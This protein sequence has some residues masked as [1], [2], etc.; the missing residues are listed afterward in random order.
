MNI[1]L[2]VKFFFFFLL[3][4]TSGHE[5]YYSTLGLSSDASSTDVKKAFRQRSLEEHPDKNEG[6]STDAFL[7]IKAAYDVLGNPSKRARYDA[8][9]DPNALDSSVASEEKIVTTLKDC[10]AVIEEHSLE[11]FVLLH[12]F[13]EHKRVDADAPWAFP[14]LKKEG[15]FLVL[16]VPIFDAE[17]ELTEYFGI[18][19]FPVLVLV[20]SR[21]RSKPFE[22]AASDVASG[23]LGPTLREAALEL[24]MASGEY[25]EATHLNWL[26]TNPEVLDLDYPFGSGCQRVILLTHSSEPHFEFYMLA[27]SRKY[28]F[29]CFFHIVHSSGQAVVSEGRA[30]RSDSLFNLFNVDYQNS[31]AL[32]LYHPI[33]QSFWHV[34]EMEALEERLALLPQQDK[35]FLRDASLETLPIAGKSLVLIAPANFDSSKNQARYE[36]AKR[37]L[38]AAQRRMHPREIQRLQVEASTA[39]AL[40]GIGSDGSTVFEKFTEFCAE[41][42]SGGNAQVACLWMRPKGIEEKDKWPRFLDEQARK[43][44]RNTAFAYG[45]DE[46]TVNFPGLNPDCAT[47]ALFEGPSRFVAV[48]EDGMATDSSV[49]SCFDGSELSQAAAKDWWLKFRGT[50]RRDD[51]KAI[52][53]MPALPIADILSREVSMGVGDF[54]VSLYQSYFWFTEFLGSLTDL[55][56]NFDIL[57]DPG[58]NPEEALKVGLS[59][60]V[61]LVFALIG[62]ALHMINSLSETPSSPRIG[63][64]SGIEPYCSLDWESDETE[65]RIY[66][67]PLE[68]RDPGTL[69]FWSKISRPSLDVRWGLRVK[70]TNSG[71]VFISFVDPKGAASEAGSAPFRLQPGDEVVEVRK[72]LESDGASGMDSIQECMRRE[73]NLLV[74]VARRKT[75]WG[76]PRCKVGLPS[77]NQKMHK[78]LR[79]LAKE[80]QDLVVD[81]NKLYEM[82]V[83]LAVQEEFSSITLEPKFEANCNATRPT[84][85]TTPAHDLKLKAMIGF[86]S[87]P[88]IESASSPLRSGDRLISR[89]E[90]APGSLQVHVA[91]WR[92]LAKCRLHVVRVRLLRSS[93]GVKW[94]LDVVAHARCV[95]RVSTGSPGFAAGVQPG[96]EVVAIN[97]EVDWPSMAREW[98]RAQLDLELVLMRWEELNGGMPEVDPSCTPEVRK[99]CAKKDLLDL[100]EKKVSVLRSEVSEASPEEHLSQRASTKISLRETGPTVPKSARQVL[101]VASDELRRLCEEI[102]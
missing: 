45:E 37:Q 60:V 92:N 81:L 78:E 39:A 58:R 62:F 75:L 86:A 70:P 90:P 85:L 99:T 95:H 19:K 38:H 34:P 84:F 74:A 79:E 10:L 20:T 1:I 15:H 72:T 102:P 42:Q 88:E 16:H 12:A 35:E 24:L 7:R 50:R 14:D 82:L 68:L 67:A 47:L 26:S 40:F 93:V 29:A 63:A 2:F 87:F 25:A 100:Q 36:N 31:P 21:K 71:T 73:L 27:R 11:K 44:A 46:T 89:E 18:T 53:S 28:P 98:A 4:S 30:K 61:I 51:E 49:S 43:Q 77:G 76:N 96:D 33:E 5:D 59:L 65:K 101:Q 66:N 80:K 13:H 23:L 22:I 9:L 17:K 6:Q 83:H 69:V 56:P 52:L 32:V 64:T 41:L 48:L 55:L 94:G 3:G 8:G 57:V 91:R 97:R 54:E